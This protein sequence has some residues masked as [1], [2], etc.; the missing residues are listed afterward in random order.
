[1]QTVM[2]ADARHMQPSALAKL[3]K[4]NIST[5]ATLQSLGLGKQFGNRVVSDRES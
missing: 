2:H 5:Y 4:M 3:G 1:M